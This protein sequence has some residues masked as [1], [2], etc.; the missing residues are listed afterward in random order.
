MLPF[1][2]LFIQGQKLFIQ[3]Q[4]LLLLELLLELL[5]LLHVFNHLLRR[6][7]EA[8]FKMHVDSW[9]QLVT[10]RVGAVTSWVQ[11]SV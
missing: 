7:G 4:I 9:I 6:G 10:A 1:E 5:V 11:L 8:P 2:N 3:T